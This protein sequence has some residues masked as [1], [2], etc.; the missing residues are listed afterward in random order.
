M[1]ESTP[2]PSRLLKASASIA[3][4]ALWFL[5]TA[6]LALA[7][8]WGAL[9]GWI[10]PRIGELRPDLEI[11]ISRVLGVPVRIGGITAQSSG[12][13]PSFELTDVVLLDAQ[14]REALRLPRVLAGLSP[15]SLWNLGFE[16]LVIDQPDVDIRRSGDGRIHVAGL[17]FSRTET[18]DGRAA[19]WFFGQTEL[20]VRRGTVHWTDELRGAPPLALRD[21]DFTM[22]NST[23]RHAMRLDA[24][25]P[26][27]WGDRFTLRGQFRQPLLSRH[28]ALWQEWDGQVFADFARVDVS[29]LRRYSSLGV[30]VTQGRGAVRT[31][32]DV[33]KG[34]LAGATADIVLADVEA[35]LGRDLAPL[36]LLSASGRLGGKRRQGGFEL[37]TQEL[38]F[39]TREGQR[40][41]G[42]NVFVA[43]SK[44]DGNT[45]SSGELRA[46]KL[47][48]EALS[49]VATRLP[50]GSVT[51]AAIQA[52]APRGL[53]DSV[54]ARWQGPLDALVKYEAKGRA[55]RLEVASRPGVAARATA[56]NRPP[57]G[58]P[59]IRGAAVDFDLT[60]AGGKARVTLRKGALEFPGVF[61][62]PVIPFDDFAADLQWQLK[63]DQISTSV[64]NLKFAN[65][66]AQGEGQVSWHTVDAAKAVTHSRFPGVLDLQATLS[67]A[68]G[69]RVHRYLP[70]SVSKNARDYVREAVTQGSA[71]S[72][73]FRVKGN[74]HDFPFGDGKSGEFRVTANVRDATYAYVPRSMTRGT[75]AWPALTQ[76]AGELVFDRNGMQMKGAQGRFAGAAG[77]QFKAEAEI[78]DL[79]A[80]AVKVKGE[81]RGP[82]Q[83]SVAIVNGSPMAALMANALAKATTT[84]NA[85]I[86]LQLD[87]PIS[88]LDQSRVQGSVTL[89]GNDVQISPDTPLLARSRGV[90]S[91]N[92]TGF[93]LAGIQ[94]RALGG[95]VKLDGS[96]HSVPAG[97]SEPAMV[98][99]AQGTASAEGLRQ[100]RELGFLSRIAKDASGSAGYNATLTL[101]RGVPEVAVTSTLQG[102]ALNL[103]PP[104]NKSAE[105]ALPLR[106]DNTLVRESL[107]SGTRLQDQ[108]VLE[109]GRIVSIA[110]VRDLSAA[111]P[112]VVRGGIG[113][114]LAAG[115]SA[116]LP[117]QGVL[118]NINLANVDI[119]AWA[120]VLEAAAG[121][122]A[123]PV[124]LGTAGTAGAAGSQGYLPTVMAVRAKELTVEGRKLHNVVVGGSRD[125]LLWRANVDA[126]ELNGYV[127]YRQPSSAGS[128][129]VA[130]RLARLNIAA[131]A[132]SEVEALLEEQPTSIPALDIVVDDFELRGKKLGRVEIDAVNRVASQGIR[133]WRLNKLTVTMPEAAFTANGNW[134]ALSA[135]AP[136]AAPAVRTGA[137]SEPRRMVMNFRFDIADSGQLLAR[138]GMKDVVR[139][140]KGRMEG[141]VS[142]LGSPL[143]LDY[144]SM[145]GNFNVNVES[146]Q[147]LKADP[148]LAK[149]LGVLSLQ[150][151]PRRLTLDFRDVFTEGFAFDFVRGD[152]TIQQGIAATNNLQMKGVN[153]AVLMEGKAD[154]ARETQDIKVVVIPEIN[155]G[156]ASLVAS[157]INPAIGVGT[158]LAQMFL[159]QPLIRAATQEFHIDGTWADPKIA[160]QP[161]NAAPTGSRPA[162]AAESKA[163]A[164]N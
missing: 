67:R 99:K 33:V 19:D 159:R 21:V 152:I 76:L 142:W 59:G 125:G 155:A 18:G 112:R 68:E 137:R 161:R 7:L 35:T 48:L 139:R 105:Q 156:T 14:G 144:P 64:T 3:Q 98:L 90:V 102:L 29:Q 95:D 96:S 30:E 80:I 134:A 28:R 146:G 119:D 124:R 89:A 45:L 93:S 83:E 20:L 140:G 154:I 52:Y 100:A 116:P 71:T 5:A 160:R 1:N 69:T 122:S 126:S 62:E 38:Q 117:E 91:F 133:E 164:N 129:L 50:L 77:L 6:W 135:Q 110:Y 143:S 4:W 157:V 108:L 66:D 12:L 32:V 130:A 92:E 148:G 31:W 41:P 85:D 101:R 120:R 34:Q 70:Q 11:E 118:A 109:L 54:Q 114:G 56:L 150:S 43:W 9:H 123:A 141:Q 162:V 44:G 131:S 25:P 61:E 22:R 136:G 26:P 75:G 84:G 111:E 60:Q 127:E 115:E 106:F 128:G 121:P 163:E 72:M 36:A 17:D 153:A 24:T 2:P 46:D 8:M 82:L 15:R 81:V 63:G 10:V 107:A 53:V 97:S 86:R 16:Q 47:D 78:A 27:E 73:K 103:P 151:L 94:A 42:G 49:Q 65:A 13:I 145:S 104:L 37:Q 40:W 55:S 138:F 51:H 113:V 87:L 74:L 39:Q 132:A 147:F 149:L 23:R 158:F 57:I 79:R 88:H 58:S